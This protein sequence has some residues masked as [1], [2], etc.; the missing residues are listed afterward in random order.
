[1]RVFITGVSSGIGRELARQLIDDGHEVWGIAR[2]VEAMAALA[3]ELGGARFRYSG[4]DIADP[5]AC[6]AVRREMD[7]ADYLPDAIVLN[8]GLDLDDAPPGLDAAQSARIMRTNYD[9]AHYWVAAFIEPFLRRGSGQFVA[10]SSIL[11]HWPDSG[12]RVLLG[13][14]GGRSRCMFREPAQPLHDLEY[15]VQTALSG[16]CGYAHKPAIR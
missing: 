6:A 14:Q 9:G 15:P 13:F 10:I 3:E 8:A 2:R 1:M 5:A 16:A 4:C 11:A 12:Q 7:A